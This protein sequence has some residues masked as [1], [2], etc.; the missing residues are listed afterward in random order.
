MMTDKTEKPAPINPAA[1]MTGPEIL[2]MAD[3]EETAIKDRH[4]N[5]R[6]E[7]SC[8]HAEEKADHATRQKYLRALAKVA[9]AGE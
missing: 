5:E 9:P 4:A 2:K 1:N 3:D 8:K 7:L 6:S